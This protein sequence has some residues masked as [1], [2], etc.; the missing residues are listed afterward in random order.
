MGKA[1]QWRQENQSRYFFR[2]L[3]REKKQQRKRNK[4]LQKHHLLNKCRGGTY[5]PTNILML[6]P[7]RH[8]E[9]HRLFRNSDPEYIIAVLRRMC[10]MKG[11]QLHEEA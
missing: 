6:A 2:K 11:Y 5:A 10:R 8:A 1:R 3:N 4:K 7:Q 9:W